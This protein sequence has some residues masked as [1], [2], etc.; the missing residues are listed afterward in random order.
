MFKKDPMDI[1]A[2]KTGNY[3]KRYALMEF[4]SQTD[5]PSGNDVRYAYFRIYKRNL[6]YRLFLAA[7]TARN[8]GGDGRCRVLDCG[9]GFA[10]DLEYIVCRLTDYWKKWPPAKNIK[11]HGIDADERALAFARKH[12]T[13]LSLDAEFRIGDIS[14]CLPYETGYFD[15]VIC[16]EVVEHLAAPENLLREIRRVLAKDGLL[17][18]T[19]NNKPTVLGAIKSLF[20]G[21]PSA[22]KERD[23][24]CGADGQSIRAHGHIHMRK[25]RYWENLCKKTGFTIVSFGSYESVQRSGSNTPASLFLFFFLNFLVSLLP[26]RIGRYFGCTTVMLLKA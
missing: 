12:W 14:V 23:D 6:L 26:K 7:L 2:E 22:E 5:S 9:C 20:T 19:T 10:S 18:F 1:D 17:V 4:Y 8:A 21:R 15:I 3:V 25:A 24:P 13:H 16:S 11:Y